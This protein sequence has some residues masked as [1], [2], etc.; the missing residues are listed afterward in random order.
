MA[1]LIYEEIIR[2]T[3]WYKRA[4]NNEDPYI[5]TKDHIENY[6]EI[7]TNLNRNYA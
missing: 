3:E 1:S 4:L 6:L 2:Q 7:I 5:I